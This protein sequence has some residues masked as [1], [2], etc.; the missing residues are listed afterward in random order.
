MAPA[1]LM[2]LVIQRLIAYSAIIIITPVV[3]VF[4]C[5]CK[6]NVRDLETLVL[7]VCHVQMVILMPV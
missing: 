1:H 5:M 4:L 6:L 7:R 2:I 3:V